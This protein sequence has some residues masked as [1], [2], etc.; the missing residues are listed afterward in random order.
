M[1]IQLLTLGSRGDVQPYVALGAALKARGHTVTVTTGQGFDDMIE[2]QGLVSAPISADVRR[3]LQDPLVQDAL[4]SFSGKIKAYRALK[5]DIGN[6][7]DEAW[8]LVRDARPDVLV[9]HQKMGA[10][11]TFGAQLGIPALPSYLI[12]G[13]VATSAYPFPLL[14]VSSL[15]KTGNRLSHGLIRWT[16]NRFY[17]PLVTRWRRERLPDLQGPAFDPFEGFDPAGRPPLRLHA[18]SAHV[19]PKPADWDDRD[20][21][22]G[23]WFQDAAS[24]REPTGELRD[25]LDAGPPPVYVGF[26]SMPAADAGAMTRVVLE[27]LERTGQRGV[28]ATVWGG[29]EKTVVPDTV[30]MLETARHDWL[31]PRC[32]A[33]VH[34]GG[35]GTTHE[36]LRWGRPTVICPFGVDQPFWGRRVAALG[37]GPDPLPRKSLTADRLAAALAATREHALITRAEDVGAA[38]RTEGGAADAAKAIERFAAA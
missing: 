30:F 4:N 14:P 26:G 22:T 21:V 2:E 18:F 16:T 13:M 11:A 23:Y 5:G 12:P 20:R 37:A 3:M 29:L 15:G 9:Y 32:S 10:A 6:Q 7:I 1:H 24:D 34:H 25:F 19:V 31:F 38:I 8:R 17:L 36:G 28:L 33:V 35:A 27:A